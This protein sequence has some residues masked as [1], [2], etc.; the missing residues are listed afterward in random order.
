M[1]IFI[2]Y[3]IVTYS[4]SNPTIIFPDE[5]DS[6]ILIT[7]YGVNLADFI[8]QAF[9]LTA[10]GITFNFFCLGGKVVIQKKTG[11]LWL[12][13]LFIALYLIFGSLFFKL[14]SDQSFW[15]PDSGNGGFLGS[16]FLT[17]AS[18]ISLQN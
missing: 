16:Y 15:L 17:L 14:Y 18:S 6:R 7:K 11:S 13:F 3:S 1:G 12:Q 9:G 4:P 10:I 5:S 8:L 2:F